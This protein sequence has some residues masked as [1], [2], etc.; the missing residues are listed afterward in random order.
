[1]KHN[2]LSCLCLFLV[3]SYTFTRA[4]NET[5]KW[6]FGAYAG[7][8][9][10]SGTPLTV[11]S[12]TM[13]APENASSIA[14][15]AGNLLFYTNSES[16]WDASHNVMANGSGIL[17][18][19]SSVQSMIVKQPGSASVYYVFTVD[20]AG[21]PD[22]LRYSTVDMSLAA[23]MGSVTAKNVLLYT[24]SSEKL[25][26]VKHCNGTD[27][28][29]ISH[30]LNGN[31][32]KAHLV[33]AAGVSN[34]PVVTTIG[35]GSGWYGQMKGSPNGRKLVNLVP[36]WG[37]PFYELYDFD[38]STG[39]LSG[40]QVL[41]ISTSTNAGLCE[42]SPDGTKLYTSLMLSSTLVQWDLCAGNAI[43][44]IPSQ[45]SGLNNYFG[46][47]QLAPDGKIYLSRIGNATLGIINNPNAAGVACGYSDMGPTLA[48][49]GLVQPTGQLGLPNFLPHYFRQAPAFTYTANCQNVSFTAPQACS[50][51]GAVATGMAWDFGD[52]AAGI[53]NQS[54]LSNPVHAYPGPGTYQAK[55]VLYYPCSTDTVKVAV[56]IVNAAPSVAVA[57]PAMICKGQAITYSVNGT[58]TYSWSSGATGTTAL[59]SPTFSA[60][61]T[62]TG[63]DP[64]SGCSNSKTFTV[65]V[66]PCTGI[67]QASAT[68]SQLAVYP[69]PCQDKI[70]VEAGEAFQLTAYNQLGALV[71]KQELNPGKTNIDI[72]ALSKGV[73][74]IRAAG[75][76][77]TII[78][79]LIK[80]E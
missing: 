72:S 50:A 41:T 11:V 60:I 22:G 34:T 70:T 45:F 5:S 10:M 65:A 66:A 28:W 46:G 79:K 17:G 9:F 12:P 58:G 80:T 23:G 36:T 21:G 42:F 62:V 3:L 44:T 32:F 2:L 4:Q 15:A 7:L 35:S 61:Y 49:N 18:N 76:A 69:N 24:P 48:P 40:L 13:M 31:G 43:T 16:I 75:R 37:A 64:V 1:M 71:L 6:I 63:T 29:L 33:T 57:G 14:D 27:V 59:L 39:T 51:T 73:Y 20:D 52:P 38:N 77:G 25:T 47:L 26:A 55:L 53:A 67:E 74:V 30:D 19:W 78:N 68:G 54:A 8:D 56:N